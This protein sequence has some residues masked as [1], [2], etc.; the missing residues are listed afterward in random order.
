MTVAFDTSKRLLAFERA[1]RQL[2]PAVVGRIAGG[3]LVLDM[4]GAAPLDE[5]LAVLKDLA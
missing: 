2:N 4:R 3:K 1:L 5:L